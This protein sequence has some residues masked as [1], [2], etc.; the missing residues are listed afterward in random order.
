ALQQV[1]GALMDKHDQELANMQENYELALEEVE[2]RFLE[3]YKPVTDVLL[4]MMETQADQMA[5]YERWLATV[6]ALAES[7]VSQAD[8]DQVYPDLEAS[9]QE[10]VA[11]AEQN[12]QAGLIE[13]AVGELQR[14]YHE[15]SL[16]L[17][18]YRSFT[19]QYDELRRTAKL[20]LAKLEQEI[21]HNQQVPGMD[22]EGRVLP[23]TI[24]VNT[25]V[26]GDF[27]RLFQEVQ[28]GL[29]QIDAPVSTGQMN[30]LREMITKRIPA[31][32]T[33]A[34]EL[35]YQARMA[36]INSQL[37]MNIASLAMKALKTQGYQIEQAGYEEEDM[38]GEYRVQMVD[39]E[40]SRIVIKVEPKP[41]AV[42]DTELHVY[43]NDQAKRTPHEMRQRAREIERSLSGAGLM[44]GEL[45]QEEAGVQHRRTIRES[46]DQNRKPV[47][48]TQVKYER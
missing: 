29:Q 4:G 40:G 41:G 5:Y 21:L 45:T 38:R 6:Q 17:T 46:A 12:V 32:Q 34:G 3:S 36:V 35:V 25:W 11:L 33:Q 8:I 43:A 48:Q 26:G 24:E 10:S 39:I 14:T 7:L 9:Y 28:R 23:Y 27:A 13:T 22:L 20:K 15:L 2:S 16:R 37:R 42:A 44:V 19:N 18:R 31:W 30:R 47:Y 1:S